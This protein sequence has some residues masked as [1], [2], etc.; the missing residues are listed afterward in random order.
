[1]LKCNLCGK[2]YLQVGHKNK[3][4]N[5]YGYCSIECYRNSSDYINERT[6]F[7]TSILKNKGLYISDMTMDEMKKEYSKIQS[8]LGKDTVT[9]KH[10]TIEKL[11]GDVHEWYKQAGIKSKYSKAIKY[12]LGQNIIPSIDGYTN[13]ELV[14]LYNSKFYKD[15]N[16][17]DKIKKSFS[18][19]ENVGDEFKRRRILSALRYF[20][21][22]ETVTYSESEIMDISKRYADSIGFKVSDKMKWKTTH[23]KNIGEYDSCMTADEVDIRYSEYISDRMM[24][25]SLQVENNGYKR[26][27]KG[28]YTFNNIKCNMFYMSSWENEVLKYLDDNIVLYKISEVCPPERIKYEIDGVNRNY[29]PDIKVVANNIEY[30]FEIKPKRKVEE[31]MNVCK[32][33]SAYKKINNFYILTEDVIFGDMNSFFN[34]VFK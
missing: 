15:Q 4:T 13:D 24:Q 34:E 14:E 8:K 18:K 29:Y 9:K 30:V 33:D 20:G 32:F 25:S 23:L 31:H 16:H 11:Y 10:K 3:K 1:M 19:Y 17:S 26:T 22:D 28:W 6:K 7:L 2:E 21:M 27:K 12:L 5:L